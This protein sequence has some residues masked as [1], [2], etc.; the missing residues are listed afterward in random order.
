MKKLFSLTSVLLFA[1]FILSCSVSK[2]SRWFTELNIQVNILDEK[3]NVVSDEIFDKLECKYV[4]GGASEI[5]KKKTEVPEKTCSFNFFMYLGNYSSEE[6]KK[7]NLASYKEKLKEM[8]I[9]IIDKSGIYKD[10]RLSPLSGFTHK[11]LKEEYGYPTHIEYT[12]KLE[13]R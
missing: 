2:I 5:E 1:V 10:C 7:I 6:Q 8:G 4:L 11:V 9:E 12:I 3:G 13:K